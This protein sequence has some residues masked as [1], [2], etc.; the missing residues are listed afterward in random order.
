MMTESQ[1]RQWAMFCH[2]GGFA[3]Y[4]IPFGNFIAP[5]VLWQ[6]KKDDPFVDD[7]GKEALNFQITQFALMMISVVMIF[8]IIGIFMVLGLFLFEVIVTILAAM[9]ASRGERY[10]YP[11][12][13]RLIS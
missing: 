11:L 6:M 1:S 4:V 5:L 7:Q 9:A 3:G 12:T 10:R 8:F 2:L 13:V